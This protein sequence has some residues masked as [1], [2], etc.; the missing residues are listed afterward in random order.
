MSDSRINPRLAVS[1]RSAVQVV[2]GRIVPSK[3]VNFSAAGIQMQIGV[4][5]KEK[6]DY[7]MMMEVPS[8]RDAS[9]RT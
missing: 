7:Q 3:I 4:M 8:P 1:W 2:P 6:Q 5:L 9:V